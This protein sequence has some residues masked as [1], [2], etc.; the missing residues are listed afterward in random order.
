MNHRRLSRRF[1]AGLTCAIALMFAPD[2]QEARLARHG[3]VLATLSFSQNADAQPMPA[4]AGDTA[5]TGVTSA[6][7]H[8]GAAWLV[9]IGLPDPSGLMPSTETLRR[10]TAATLVVFLWLFALLTCLYAARHYLFS[11][12]RL[13]RHQRAPYRHIVNAEWPMLTVYVAAHNEEAVVSDCLVA[14]L[15]TTYPHD[16][17]VIVPVNDRSTDGTRALIDAVQARA[18]TLI[19]PFHRDSG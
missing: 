15:A 8:A 18:P 12:D 14:L 16:R 4:E 6:E 10:D 1:A 2:M 5:G 19:R 11:L 7:P 13:F 17:L 3:T 9:P